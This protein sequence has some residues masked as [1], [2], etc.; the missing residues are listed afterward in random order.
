MFFLSSQYFLLFSF[1]NA[2]IFRNDLGQNNF[3]KT[4]IN[5]QITLADTI[6]DVHQMHFLFPDIQQTCIYQFSVSQWS[7]RNVRK[8]DW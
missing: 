6:L 8:T 1:S 4:E 3:L 2:A 7:Q 5:N